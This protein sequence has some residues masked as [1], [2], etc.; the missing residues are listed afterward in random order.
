[1]EY[2][3]AMF[4][5]TLGQIDDMIVKIG[6]TIN[7]FMI[8]N[9]I[10][11]HVSLVRINVSDKED[12]RRTIGHFLD[13]HPSPIVL[14]TK[15]IG[16]FMEDTGTVFID[17]E[18]NED[19]GKLQKKYFRFPDATFS[20]QTSPENYHPHLTLATHLTEEETKQ[21]LELVSGMKVPKTL[22]P[23]RVV[24]LEPDI[25]QS[26]ASMKIRRH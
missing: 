11:S 10:E 19:L 21:V 4:F 15:G 18:N 14:K 23:N 17:I 6:K 25:F 7:P 22:T 16:S 1:M 3:I 13:F 5:D 8:E 12:R 2:I 9:N 20:E 26:L 24:F